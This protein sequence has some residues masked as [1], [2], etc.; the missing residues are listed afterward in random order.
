MRVK[1][2]RVLIVGRGAQADIRLND[3]SV[4]RQHLELVLGAGDEIHVA[5]RSS[6]NGTRSWTDGKWVP[7]TA[8]SVSPADRLQL[9]NLEITVEDLV[10]RA[11]PEPVDAPH[12]TDRGAG[13]RPVAEPDLDLP[14]GKVR[15]NPETGKV[16]PV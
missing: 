10:R 12:H 3:S 1:K 6:R 4:S 8:K 11:P 7:L 13:G 5:D 15:R 9:G 2:H 14:T 16:V